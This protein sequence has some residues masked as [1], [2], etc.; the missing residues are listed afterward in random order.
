MLRKGWNVPGFA[1]ARRFPASTGPSWRP[2]AILS[3][4]FSPG[5]QE[6]RWAVQA[7]YFARRLFDR[8]M[9][10]I[11]TMVENEKGLA[12]AQRALGDF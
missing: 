12:D 5:F 2:K 11:E 3:P 7:D 10:G 6:N 4:C 1:P 8:D 9:T